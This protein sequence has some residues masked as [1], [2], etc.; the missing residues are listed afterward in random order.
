MSM[1]CSTKGS[2]TASAGVRDKLKALLA[3]EALVGVPWGAGG[4]IWNAAILHFLQNLCTSAV[5]PSGARPKPAGLQCT[6]L[7]HASFSSIAQTCAI[8]MKR[9]LS[10]PATHAAKPNGGRHMRAPPGTACMTLFKAGHIEWGP[11][12]SPPG[13]GCCCWASPGR[14]H[15]PGPLPA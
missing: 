4:T 2:R 5:A 13:G 8:L 10:L 14:G 1:R 15:A 6:Q 9:W 3:D 12:V 7:S 11:L